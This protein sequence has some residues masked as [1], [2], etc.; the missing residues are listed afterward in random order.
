MS[1]SINGGRGPTESEFTDGGSHEKTSADVGISR[2]VWKE[3]TVDL[4]AGYDHQV[5]HGS[6]R[7]SDVYKFNASANY[8]INRW[9]TAD[10]K[11]SHKDKRE[12]AETS[13]DR[14]NKAS[15]GLNILF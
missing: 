3:L 2:R 6:E 7:K 15:V 12:N 13:S 14:L 9:M 5:F 4:K 10:F 8:V 1:M 11:Y